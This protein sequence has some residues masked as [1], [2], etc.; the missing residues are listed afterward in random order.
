MRGNGLKLMC[1]RDGKT[2]NENNHKCRIPN[3]NKVR[4]TYCIND[5]LVQWPPVD[6]EHM[7]HPTLS[8]FSHASYQM[9]LAAGRESSK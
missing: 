5:S 4:V 6:S 8:V 1:V 7:T 9:S 3:S 2:E